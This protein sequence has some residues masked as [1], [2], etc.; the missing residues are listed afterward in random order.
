MECLKAYKLQQVQPVQYEDPYVRLTMLPECDDPAAQGQTLP[1]QDA[2]TT[3]HWDKKLRNKV[4]LACPQ[5]TAIRELG[6]RIEVV[7]AKPP[8]VD[9]VMGSAEIHIEEFVDQV[10]KT[11]RK[12]V[13]LVF[14]EKPVGHI[15]LRMTFTPL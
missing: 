5:D 10:T 3:P 2:G 15:D 4:E 12:T 14:E 7:N 1:D 11:I 8:K 13:D 9:M 6:L